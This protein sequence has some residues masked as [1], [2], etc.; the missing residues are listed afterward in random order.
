MTNHERDHA[1]PRPAANVSLL[2]A[3]P[4][5][6]SR[7]V[8]VRRPTAAVAALPVRLPRRL[9]VHPQNHDPTNP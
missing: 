8:A 4:V 2:P 5:C 7:A 3:G 1:D 6:V 9:A